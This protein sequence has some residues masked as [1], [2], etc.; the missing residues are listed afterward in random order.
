MSTV[1]NDSTLAI[2]YRLL[3]AEGT[4][5]ETTEGDELEVVELGIGELPD[6]VEEA[7]IGRAV[8]DDVRVE[9]SEPFGAADPNAIVSIPR[10]AFAEAG[11]IEDLEPGDVVPILLAPEEGDDS[12]EPEE[13]EVVVRE[14][15]ED[16]V[17][18]DLNHPF[19]GLDVVFEIHV[20]EIRD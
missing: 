14:I 4:V 10:D 6:V 5:L 3:D 2:R 12:D 8:G 1:K 13:V 17:V 16:G 7:L 15:N 20:V 11:E 19:A 18:V 9:A